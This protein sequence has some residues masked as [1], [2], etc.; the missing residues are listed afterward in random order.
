VAAP[1]TGHGD[2]AGLPGV[3][4]VAAQ[5]GRVVL[6]TTDSDATVLALAAAGLVRDLEVA[7][8]G[9]EDAYVALTSATLVTEG[10]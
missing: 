4:T 8:V 6:T 5:G 3:V 2:L 1:A 9:L 10:V 7:G